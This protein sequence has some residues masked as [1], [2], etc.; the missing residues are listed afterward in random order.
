MKPVPEDQPE[1]VNGAVTNFDPII[2][3]EN[4]LIVTIG[5]INCFFTPTELKEILTRYEPILGQKA[6]RSVYYYFLENIAA[7]APLI[8]TE[9]D[10]SVQAIHR[11]VKWLNKHGFIEAIGKIKGV[12]KG[13]PRPVLYAL[14]GATGEQIARAR[15]KID[16][17]YR[18]SFNL[19]KNLTQKIFDDI[20]DEEIQYAKI[21]NLARKNSKGFDFIDI[22]DQVAREL[23]F[24]GIK[25]WR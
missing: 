9:S 15:I 13:G 20:K 10:L 16:K 19:V 17:S 4:Q 18:D 2:M 8:A 6:R 7:T 12:K 23:H 22:A 11:H 21:V 25:V 14:P 5:T 3:K 24:R 1:L